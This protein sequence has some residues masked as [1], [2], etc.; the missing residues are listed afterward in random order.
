[1]PAGRTAGAE[2]VSQRH[3]AA[4]RKFGKLVNKR[5]LT[6]SDPVELFSFRF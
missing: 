4:L 1:M 3:P 6:P 2:V 5:T